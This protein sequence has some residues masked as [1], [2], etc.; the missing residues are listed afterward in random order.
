MNTNWK[1]YQESFYNLSADKQ[2]NLTNIDSEEDLGSNAICLAQEELKATEL[3]I[4][5]QKGIKNATKKVLD[6]ITW[7]KDVS[8][9]I[10]QE[11]MNPKDIAIMEEIK[12]KNPELYAKISPR[13]S[14]WV[15]HI[16]IDLPNSWILK[17]D[18]KDL[19]NMTWDNANELAKS[20]W[21]RLL[22]INEL[23]EIVE[24]IWLD[25]TRKIF[26]L[27]SHHY[28]SS[29]TSAS[30]TFYARYMNFFNAYTDGSNKTT[31]THRVI[32]TR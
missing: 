31:T 12:S 8:L 4:A 16:Q 28:W 18:R 15:D 29:T 23:K 9:D 7:V 6:D 2:E 21:K 13:L 10:I 25:E 17:I 1:V 27:D 19:W 26:W 22:T 20:L 14:Y 32:C 11:N 30:Y 3:I 5:E 24:F